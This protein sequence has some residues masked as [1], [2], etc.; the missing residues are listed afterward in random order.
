MGNMHVILNGEAF[1]GSAASHYPDD[2]RNL[3]VI[4]IQNLDN[5]PIQIEILKED[6]S[7]R[8]TSGVIAPY[9]IE[10]L[11]IPIS[12]LA[13]GRVKVC[14]WNSGMVGVGVFGTGGEAIFVCPN[15]GTVAVNLQVHPISK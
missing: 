8:T 5:V 3:V 14:R 2:V 9:A 11:S 13:N 10:N 7:F 15:S 6:Y 12:K 4:K 1:K